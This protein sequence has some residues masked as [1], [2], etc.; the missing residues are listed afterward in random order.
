MLSIGSQR[1]VKLCAVVRVYGSDNNDDDRAA[2]R[3]YQIL[4][5]KPTN[6]DEFVGRSLRL[7]ELHI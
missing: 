1:F 7:V 3:D 4:W 6:V 5:R 2:V